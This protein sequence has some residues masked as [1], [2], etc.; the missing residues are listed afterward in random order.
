MAESLR[1]AGVSAAAAILGASVGAVGTYVATEKVLEGNQ[2]VVQKQIAAN[3]A[4]LQSQV[5]RE[6]RQQRRTARGVARVYAEQLGDALEILEYAQKQGRWPGRN[7][8]SYF[9]LPALEDRRLIQSRLSDRS[10]GAVVRADSAMRAMTSIIEV[11]P[12]HHL[13]D[14][15]RRLI[16][17]FERALTHGVDALG[18]ME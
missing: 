3:Q 1:I 16:R 2:A 14:Q 6:D 13:G 12:E 4:V 9:V 8:L 17:G 5:D 11:V 10:S 15:T 18:E 7:N